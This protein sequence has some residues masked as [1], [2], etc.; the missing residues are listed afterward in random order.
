LHEGLQ[1]RFGTAPISIA[2]DA[3]YRSMHPQQG[4]RLLPVSRREARAAITKACPATGEQD[5]VAYA[6]WLPGLDDH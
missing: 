3:S 4:T 2:Q 6:T 1:Q 5:R